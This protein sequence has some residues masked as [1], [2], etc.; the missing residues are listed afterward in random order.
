MNEVA[1]LIYLANN[2]LEIKK[3]AKSIK[4]DF[5]Q[6]GGPTWNLPKAF[7]T[8]TYCPEVPIA[9]GRGV[10]CVCISTIGSQLFQGIF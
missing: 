8:S 1:E 3:W 9:I 5:A 10:S 4:N 6:E 7:G 2:E